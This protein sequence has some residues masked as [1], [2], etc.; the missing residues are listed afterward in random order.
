MI[1][2]IH[3]KPSTDY[4]HDRILA[5]VERGATVLDLGAGLGSYHQKL[6]QRGVT[7]TTVDA[8]MPYVERQRAYAD[9]VH[10]ATIQ[11]FIGVVNLV[12]D[13]VLMIDVIE[14]LP[15]AEALAALQQLPAIAAH[16]VIFT[17]RGFISQTKDVYELG[18]DHWQT[19]RTGWEPE[20]LESLGY[21]VEVWRDFHFREDLGK[22]DALYATK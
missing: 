7:L 12:Y 11:D 21:D 4:L 3:V 13:C 5:E 20:E 10:H 1:K 17:P 19:H 18:G 6:K 22:F 9:F 15:K 2:E 14:H 16:S 8:H